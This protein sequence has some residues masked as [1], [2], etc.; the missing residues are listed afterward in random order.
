MS[1]TADGEDLERFALFV[2]FLEGY[3]NKFTS[4]RCN[5]SYS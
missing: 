3:L 1:L 5:V 4:S 2:F